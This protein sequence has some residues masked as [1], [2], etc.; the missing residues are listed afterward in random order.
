MK[1]ADKRWEG[2]GCYSLIFGCC[3]NSGALP[4]RGKW[5]V[6]LLGSVWTSLSGQSSSIW[7]PYSSQIQTGLRLLILSFT[8]PCVK[9]TFYPKFIL[10][11]PVQYLVHNANVRENLNM[12]KFL[13]CFQ[14]KV[15]RE[16]PA[17]TQSWKIYEVLIEQLKLAGIALIALI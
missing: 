1:G 14:N 17:I 11:S 12:F 16:K 2:E 15:C 4:M 5:F 6:A 9:S 3:V 7:N 13:S 8:P 10:I